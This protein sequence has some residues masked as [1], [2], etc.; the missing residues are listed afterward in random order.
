MK[1]ILLSFGLLISATLFFSCNNDDKSGSDKGASGD[2]GTAT[3]TTDTANIGTTGA[4]TN[5]TTTPVSSTDRQ[6][7]ME[8]ASGGMMEVEAGRLAEQ[9]ATH[10]RVKN[11]GT[12][13][14]RD[15]SNANNELR[16]L[17][18]SKN[19]TLPDTM[20]AKHRQ[21]LE[22]LRT[23]TGKAFD[24]SYISMMNTDHSEDINKFQ[25]AANNAQDVD[26]KAFA[27]KTLPVLRMHKDSVT[28]IN[29]NMK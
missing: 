24:R 5:T 1:R 17:A 11:F 16:A 26:I 13:M 2:L 25:V 10:P 18:T 23:K 19:I 3:V 20:M 21:H 27:N 6:F 29:K 14:I 9:N 28:A 22:M 4:T 8:A 15:H 7:I 12:M